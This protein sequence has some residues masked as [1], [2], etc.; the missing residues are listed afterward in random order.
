MCVVPCEQYHVRAAYSRSRT[1]EVVDAVMESPPP[2]PTPHLCMADRLVI[3]DVSPAEHHTLAGSQLSVVGDGDVRG[4]ARAK[5]AGRASRRMAAVS[6][7]AWLEVLLGSAGGL[8]QHLPHAAQRSDSLCVCW[9]RTQVQQAGGRGGTGPARPTVVHTGDA[10]NTGA[11]VTPVS[12]QHETAAL[13]QVTQQVAP[14]GKALRWLAGT[15]MRTCHE[16][17]A[18]LAHACAHATRQ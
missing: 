8:W 11:A 4:R 6:R 7:H 14:C 13:L 16:A 9:D 12:T 17:V 18:L 2:P 3:D 5:P 1:A 15:R 10:V